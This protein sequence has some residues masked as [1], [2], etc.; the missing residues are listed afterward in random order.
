MTYDLESVRNNA[1]SHKLLS[2]VTTVH[3]QGVGKTLDDWAL[4]LSESLL[5]VSTGGVGDIDWG[6]NL[7]VIAIRSTLARVFN[8]SP[9]R[10]PMAVQFSLQCEWDFSRQRDISD[11]DILIT[12]LVEKLDASNLFSDLLGQDLVARDGL[13]FDFSS[14][15]HDGDG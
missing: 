11:L 12:P 5:G 13:D 15:R 4:C 2:V 14:V 10:N 7:N 9:L 8:F 6:A 3:H 1:N